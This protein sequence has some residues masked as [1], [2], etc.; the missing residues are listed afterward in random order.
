MVRAK[1]RSQSLDDVLSCI[2]QVALHCYAKRSQN[3][4]RLHL[5]AYLQWDW[6]HSEFVWFEFQCLPFH[7]LKLIQNLNCIVRVEIKCAFCD[8]IQQVCWEIQNDFKESRVFPYYNLCLHNL[9][10]PKNCT[11]HILFQFSLDSLNLEKNKVLFLLTF[12]NLEVYEIRPI[13]RNTRLDYER[14]NYC[15]KILSFWGASLPE[16]KRVSS[17]YSLV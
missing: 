12:L 2:D 1:W 13:L 17:F 9:Y 5:P 11:L 4:E 14:S 15:S 3:D 6:K 7:L 8:K 10:N 16:T